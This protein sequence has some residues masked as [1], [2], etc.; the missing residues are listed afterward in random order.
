MKLFTTNTNITKGQ[1]F[2]TVYCIFYF[3]TAWPESG[4]KSEVKNVSIVIYPISSLFLISFIPG[5]WMTK[6]NEIVVL[7][8]W[9]HLLLHCES[10]RPDFGSVPVHGWKYFIHLFITEITLVKVMNY[11]PMASGSGPISV[12]VCSVLSATFDHNIQYRH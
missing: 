3:A 11:H 12:P 7:L 10:N 9:A 5:C 4:P 8:L 2:A 1:I 6:C